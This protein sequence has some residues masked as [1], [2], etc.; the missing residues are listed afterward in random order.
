VRIK[1][2]ESNNPRERIMIEDAVVVSY[3]TPRNEGRND[4]ERI[5]E[6]RVTTTTDKSAR[7]GSER[8][9]EMTPLLSIK[10]VHTITAT[11]VPM[12]KRNIFSRSTDNP[13]FGRKK[14]TEIIPTIPTRKKLIMRTLNE[15]RFGASSVCVCSIY[16]SHYTKKSP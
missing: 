12:E 15:E 13:M 2:Y 1:K 3:P 5:A 10:S 14:N 16:T 9:I 11:N 4:S 8:G 6:T 7:N